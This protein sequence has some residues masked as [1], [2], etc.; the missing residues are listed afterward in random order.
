MTPQGGPSLSPQAV[1][2]LGGCAP[3]CLGCTWGDVLSAKA[4]PWLMTSPNLH[5][6]FL[7]LRAASPS[8]SRPLFGGW[9]QAGVRQGASTWLPLCARASAE[10]GMLG[11]RCRGLVPQRNRS[12]CGGSQ[13]EA[14]TAHPHQQPLVSSEFVLWRKRGTGYFGEVWEALWLSWVSLAVKVIKSGG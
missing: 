2:V 14:L 12:L 13:A 5:L 8:S 3:S 10:S 7:S 1:E 11:Q 6:L 9:G 4:P